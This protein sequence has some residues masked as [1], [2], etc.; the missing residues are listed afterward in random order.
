[1]LERLLYLQPALD[2]L[3]LFEER[4]S[5]FILTEGDWNMLASVKDILYSFHDSTTRLSAMQ[6]P[7]LLLQLQYYELLL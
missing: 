1:M 7:T 6:Y 5:E 3:T 4:L 2:R